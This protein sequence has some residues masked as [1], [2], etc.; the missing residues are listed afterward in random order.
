M[1]STLSITAAGLLFG[2][3][4]V[5]QDAVPATPPAPAAPAPPSASQP[6]IPPAAPNPPALIPNQPDQRVQTRFLDAEHPTVLTI[7][8]GCSSVLYFPKPIRS[9]IGYG[10]ISGQGQETGPVQY[11]HPEGSPVVALRAVEGFSTLYMTVLVDESLYVFE[12]HNGPVPVVAMKLV[13]K[14]ANGGAR[15]V[16][17]ADIRDER[18]HSSPEDLVGLLHKAIER[19]ILSKSYASLYEHSE[20]RKADAKTNYGDVVCTVTEVHRFSDADATVIIGEIKNNNSYAIQF[21]P[22]A[23]GVTLGAREYPAQLC[24]ARGT[25]PAK[26]SAPIGIVLRGDVDGSRAHLSLKNDYRIALPQYGRYA[27]NSAA[28]EPPLPKSYRSDK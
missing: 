20:W 3:R 17:V 2:L 27:A 28:V 5:A 14:P 4:A 23:V 1:K 15:E 12:L 18:I 19:P 6:Q 26:S 10:L 11:E 21:D 16:G 22:L 8:A 13:E 7:S 9:V 25:V 24:D